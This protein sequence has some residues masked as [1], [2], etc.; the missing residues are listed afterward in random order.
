VLLQRSSAKGV[1]QY[2]FPMDEE[3]TALSRYLYFDFF[4]NR[5]SISSAKASPMRTAAENLW[6]C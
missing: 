3:R 1:A 5:V 6:S 2:H 4:F